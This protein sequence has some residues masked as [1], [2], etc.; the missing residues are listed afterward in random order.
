MQSTRPRVETPIPAQPPIPNSAIGLA[1]SAGG[2]EAVGS[3]LASLPKDLDA[4]IFVVIHLSPHYR[5]RLPEIFARRCS[6]SVKTAEED[7]EL[8][9]GQ[10]YVAREDRHLAIGPGRRLRLTTDAKRHHTR[11]S[12]E[13]LFISIAREFGTSSVLVVLTGGGKNGSESLR[14]AKELGAKVL[15]QDPTG[16][17]HPGMPLAAIATGMVD[18]VLPLEEIPGRLTQ[19][20]HE[21]GG[22]RSNSHAPQ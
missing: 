8:R 13:P 2:I 18:E 16:A 3:I 14:E 7:E 4:A 11:P 20:V 6:L 9:T 17:R 19:W 22:Q 5:S 21:L 10:V 12:A 15:V 1:A